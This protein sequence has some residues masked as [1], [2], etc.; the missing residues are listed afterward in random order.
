MLSLIVVNTPPVEFGRGVRSGLDEMSGSSVSGITA[1]HGLRGDARHF[2]QSRSYF[3]SRW[4]TILWSS[5]VGQPID[6][7][8][9]RRRSALRQIEE[10]TL[11]LWP[12]PPYTL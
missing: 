8:A 4:P 10:S 3:T 12:P 6:Q 1:S 5:V 7:F 2:W 11:G 9:H